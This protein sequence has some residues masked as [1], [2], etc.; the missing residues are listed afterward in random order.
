MRFLYGG[1][2]A[3][4]TTLAS[5]RVVP[6][7]VG[8][9]WTD[10]AAGS[11]VTD[12]TDLAGNPTVSVA[13]DSVGMTLFY[14]PDGYDGPLWLDYG[15]GYRTLVRPVG[16]AGGSGAEAAP[17]VYEVG[18]SGGYGLLMESEVDLA[19]ELGI[20][21]GMGLTWLRIDVD[22]SSIEAVQGVYDWS[23]PDRGVA[24]AQAHGMKVLGILAYTPTWAQSVPGDDKSPPVDM[25]DFAE[26]CGLAAA[27]YP[28]VDAWEIWNEAN[29]LPFWK[30]APSPTDYTEMVQASY[31][32]IKAAAPDAT[33]IA[34]GLSPAVTAPGGS[35]APAEF[36]A[37]CYAA[38]IQGHF[39]AW[40]V[41]PYCYPAMPTDATT[42]AWNTFQRL[43]LV[44]EAMVAG[45]DADKKIWLTEYGAPT[46]TD[47]TAV[48]D[49]GQAAIYTEALIQ[50]QVWAEW[51]GPLFLYCGRD[52]GTDESDREQMFGFIRHDWTSKV[53]RNALTAALRDGLPAAAGSPKKVYVS[54]E[55]GTERYVEFQ[56]DGVTRWALGANPNVEDPLTPG[57]GSDLV[58]ARYDDAGD[59][60][61]NPLDVDRETGGVSMGYLW[62]RGGRIANVSEVAI[63]PE[64]KATI[65]GARDGDAALA[66]LLTALET[67]GLIVDAT[68]PATG[69]GGG[70]TLDV[71]G[72]ATDEKLV[73]FYSEAAL[74]WAAG[75][76]VDSAGAG[77][78]IHR[79]VGGTYVDTPIYVSNVSGKV[80]LNQ[81]DVTANVDT[82]IVLDVR[83]FDDTPTASF[84]R[85]AKRSGAWVFE[86]AWDGAV[87]STYNVQPGDSADLLTDK[88]YVDSIKAGVKAVAAASSDFAD[89]KTRMA[90][91]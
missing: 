66:D 90:A 24:A 84:F 31:A 73:R 28:Q 52:R 68:S 10:R 67:Y 11:P 16:S 30:P 81:A 75:I 20:Y 61:D 22:W 70:P 4:V 3:D 36:T 39:D 89:F 74:K 18:I 54:N 15:L 32:A 83:S 33:V 82:T 64:V 51:T 27:R 13:S 38:G 19:R 80:S 65:S 79:F 62:M 42:A 71:D 63:A 25:G 88:A 46:G 44:R 56:T 43:P 50:A 23:T 34:G 21:Q 78:V 6:G 59:W 85:A 53:G 55:A 45:G 37:A 40:S 48:T 77:W 76:A 2:A 58:I 35:I 26:F 60:V 72:L 41:H 5:G 9:A 49:A 87:W 1:T 12:L 29:H 14:G 57:S 47:P 91:W 17:P 86:V 69:G 7:A 8:Y